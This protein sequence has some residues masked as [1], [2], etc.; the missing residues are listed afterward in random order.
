MDEVK[1]A[2]TNR[3]IYVDSESKEKL[4]K[5]Q[6]EIEQSQIETGGDLHKGQK[7]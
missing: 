5:N 2:L 7:F 4:S 3:N 6:S 1:V